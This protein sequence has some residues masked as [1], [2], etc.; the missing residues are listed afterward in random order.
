MYLA[1]NRKDVAQLFSVLASNEAVYDR[2]IKHI[3][4]LYD[5]AKERLEKNAV[6]ALTTP[7]I[8]PFALRDKGYVDALDDILVFM[9]RFQKIGAKHEP[10]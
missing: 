3:E 2:L 4:Q 1:N 8:V 9:K 6:A 10:K 7:S 5:E